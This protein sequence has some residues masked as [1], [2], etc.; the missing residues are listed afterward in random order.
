[1][2]ANAFYPF[3]P[4][5][6]LRGATRS[7]A[8]DGELISFQPTLPLRGATNAV[9][10]SLNNTMFQPTLPLRG[11]TSRGFP[12]Q[13]HRKVST[14]APLAGSDMMSSLTLIIL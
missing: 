7:V 4:T 12:L 10:A 1:M 9:I 2:T 3:Q 8:F 13:R 14:H 6:P 5:L 11:A